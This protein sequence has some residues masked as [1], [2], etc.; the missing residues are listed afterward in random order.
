M[1]DLI[2]NETPDKV[3]HF[4]YCAIVYAGSVEAMITRGTHN[5]KLHR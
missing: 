3:S 5:E 2:Y 1:S 4:F